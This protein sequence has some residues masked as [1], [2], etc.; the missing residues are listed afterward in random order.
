M[1]APF[2]ELE[3]DL[4]PSEVGTSGI[5]WSKVSSLLFASMSGI[6]FIVGS[7][8]IHIRVTRKTHNYAYTD[9][10]TL[11]GPPTFLD[12]F[13]PNPSFYMLPQRNFVQMGLTCSIGSAISYQVKKISTDGRRIHIDELNQV[14]LFHNH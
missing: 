8:L 7:P 1:R 13:E 2:P 6:S 12:G 5:G 9:R 3:L 4:K 14:S 11:H 10:C